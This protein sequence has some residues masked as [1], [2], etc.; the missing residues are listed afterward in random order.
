MSEVIKKS[1][2]KR[3]MIA[4]KRESDRTM[5]ELNT[6]KTMQI[7][8]RDLVEPG[9]TIV[10]RVLP[11]GSL[12]NLQKESVRA[13]RRFTIGERLKAKSVSLEAPAEK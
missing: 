5:G 3:H 7:R 12:F 8:S 4:I 1:N 13:L 11:D 10:K 9:V 2:L 6:W